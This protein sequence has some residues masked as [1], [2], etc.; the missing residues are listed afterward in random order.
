MHT[1]FW[2]WFIHSIGVMV[3]RRLR[4][5]WKH[6]WEAELLHREAM[7]AEWDRLTWRSKF[8]LLWRSTSAFWDALWM[9]SYRWEDE[10]IQDLRFGFRMLVRK[11]GF[12]LVAVLTLA[13]GIG[14][15]T[16]IF[17][18]VNALLLRSL[19]YIE[20][21]RLVMLAE[22]TAT[23][24]RHEVAYPNYVD[25]R[26]RAQSFVGMA[27]AHTSSFIL[28]GADTP[29][30]LVGWV[31]NWNFFPLLG[32]KPQIGRLFTESDDQLGAPRTAVL[33][34]ESWRN[35]FGA[36]ADIIGRDL[37]LDG[38]P[39]TVIGVLPPGFEYL[40]PEDVYVPIGIF[41]T[42]ESPMLGR[43]NST[44]LY[45]VARLKPGVTINQ[46]N[47]EMM[48]IGEQ[49]EREYPEVNKG[50]SA[51]AERLQDVMS[52]NVRQ[53]LWILFAA[54]GFILL[55]ACINVA[56][57]QQVRNIDRKSVV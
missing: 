35:R 54:V 4:A 14:A 49:L 33:S 12:T 46:A 7:L 51:Q 27:A 36:Q 28:T 22:R 16:A 47:N 9:Q 57:Q 44:D 29:A 55:I 32:I 25:W 15:N 52:E 5:D 39:Y 6:E 48:S 10:M 2:L 38:N 17:S 1:K 53:S 56:N 26:D 37:T 21:D 3:P 13:L 31:G 24:E 45:A 8:D 43:G 41:L 40:E 20:S 42:P 34:N 18:V 23:G 19:P 50:T 30:R 11:P